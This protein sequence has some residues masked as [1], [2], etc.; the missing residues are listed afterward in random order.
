MVTFLLLAISL[1]NPDDVALLMTEVVSS[2]DPGQR[3][4]WWTTFL[5]QGRKGVTIVKGTGPLL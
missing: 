5:C 1:T 2:M 4:E 3:A